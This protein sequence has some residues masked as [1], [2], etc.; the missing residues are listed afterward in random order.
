M[1]EI[2]DDNG[3]IHSGS[4]EEMTKA[5]SIMT[6]PEDYSKEEVKEWEC[7]QSGDLRL[8]QIMDVFA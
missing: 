5:F 6:S 1:W 2:T 8:I 4:E 3:T 7:S